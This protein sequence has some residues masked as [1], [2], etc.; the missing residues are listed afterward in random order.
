MTIRLDKCQSFGA[1]KLNNVF[2]Q[3]EPA[4]YLNNNKIPPV[5]IGSSF[6]YLGKIFDLDGKNQEAK[7][8]IVQKLSNLLNITSNLKITTQTKLKIYQQY[9]FSQ[10]TFELKLYK[11]G[12]TWVNN[13][14]D[15]ESIRHIRNWLS[16]PPS[17]C[18]QELITTSKSK[19]GF[20]I[21]SF[22]QTYEKLLLKNRFS[23]KNNEQPEMQQIW[24]DTR[25]IHVI[26]DALIEGNESIGSATRQ[27]RAKHN[28]ASLQHFLSLECQGS[29]ARAI[30][31]GIQRKEIIIWSEH[32]R[33]QPQF[34][35]QFAYKALLQLLPTASNLFKWKR[36]G[37]PHCS[38]CNINK[39]QTNLHTLSNC[40]SSTAL[41]RYTTRHNTILEIISNWIASNISK[42]QTLYVDS[43]SSTFGSINEIFHEASRPDIVISNKTEV[44]VL[45][46][47]VC[48]ESNIE[49]SRTYKE[50]KYK[51]L[52]QNLKLNIPSSKLR[53]FT[54]EI[55]V[56]GF[57]SDISEF[58]KFAKLPKLPT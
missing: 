45:E 40:S 4:I 57:I 16:L 32:I 50:N 35:L 48:H 43:P 9:I 53:V 3:I 13:N 31:K 41:T 11:L 47:T 27:L 22:Q 19:G 18:V 46:L 25:N 15:S 26:L 37:S 33:T 23:L 6:T 2:S 54:L 12:T 17:A 44:V 21:P 29:S 30:I 38:L 1:M 39:S 55:T 58:L 5:A 51:N 56:L 14:M 42:D 36:I 24:T 34:I 7:K 8:Q 10:L 52:H 20:G 28:E 49:K